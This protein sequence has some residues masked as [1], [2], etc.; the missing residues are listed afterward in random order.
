MAEY[1]RV[2]RYNETEFK[3]GGLGVL[4]N[5]R[6]ICISSSI[7]GERTLEFALSPADEKARIVSEENI[8]VCGGQRYRIKKID[9]NKITAVAIYNDAAFKHIQYIGDMIGDTPYNIMSAIFADTP[10]NVLSEDAVKALG[11]EWVT[12]ATDFFEM[13]KVTPLGAMKSL[14]DGL[15]KY[16]HHCEVYVDNYNIALVKQLGR[17]KGARLDTAYNSKEMTVTRDTSELITRLYPYGKD[18]LHIASVNNGNQY[19]D[20]PNYSKLAREGYQ[21]FDELENPTELKTAA[22]RLFAAD[23]PNR[24]DIPKYSVKV[25]YAQRK[26]KEICLGDIV[27]IVDRDYGIT[28][29][30]RAIEVK[31]YP[32][33]PNRNEVTVGSMIKSFSQVFEGMAETSAKYQNTVNAKGEVKPSWLENLKSSMSTNINKS[34]SDISKETRK[35]VIHDYGDIWVNPNNTNQALAIIGGVIALANGRTSGGDW[36]WSAFGD[37]SGFTADVINTGTLNTSN[38]VIKSEDGK[39]HLA[40]N[41]LRMNDSHNVLRLKMGLDGGS[42]AFTLYDSNEEEVFRVNDSGNIDIKGQ[43]DTTKAE[44]EACGYLIMDDEIVGMK[45][46]A[47]KWIYHGLVVSSNKDDN[48]INLMLYIDDVAALN[49]YSYVEKRVRKTAFGANNTAY[50]ENEPSTSESNPRSWTAFEFEEG[51]AFA[52]TKMYGEWNVDNVAFYSRSGLA[53]RGYAPSGT[54]VKDGLKWTIKNGLVF[55]VQRTS[56]DDKIELTY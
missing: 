8:C 41:L 39:T 30:Q 46:S 29:K 52:K 31:E 17:D 56:N 12:D 51:S 53:P 2:Y 21:D 26:A 45:Y 33:E 50:N 54:V 10:V 24:I 48:T 28:S 35:T 34:L 9:G 47:S 43:L 16:G 19:I 23:N 44:D 5:A 15:E 13:S 40:D 6:D 25:S 1:I 11:M 22:E 27:T 20:S 38:V 7:D 18:G 55:G 42:Y 32:F 3:S 14:T 37:W 36:N 4:H 49:I